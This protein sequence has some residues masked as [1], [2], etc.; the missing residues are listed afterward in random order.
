MWLSVT[1][2]WRGIFKD[3]NNYDKMFELCDSAKKVFQRKGMS[4]HVAECEMDIASWYR[5][6]GYFDK[7]LELLE[8]ARNIFS[9]NNRETSL[10]FC[11][12][13]IGNLFAKMSKCDQAI[14]SFEEAKRIFRKK[15]QKDQ[16]VLCDINMAGEYR[17]KGENERAISLLQRGLK[18]DGLFLEYR[19]RGFIELGRNFKDRG[20]I[21]RSRKYFEKAIYLIEDVCFSFTNEELQRL[22]WDQLARVYHEMAEVCFEEKDFESS[23]KY[24][25]KQ[26]SRYI[27][28]GMLEHDLAADNCNIRRVAYSRAEYSFGAVSG[29]NV[30]SKR[31]NRLH[32]GSIRS[33]KAIRKSGNGIDKN[34]RVRL[35]L[36]GESFSEMD[37]GHAKEVMGNDILI[38]L[39]PMETGTGR[40][41]CEEGSTN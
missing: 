1:N 30:S 31:H 26:K 13:G 34:N 35:V 37:Y 36:A 29:K 16:V 9:E 25:E 2:K 23:F 7:A 19:V 11:N 41:Y 10:A 32:H 22:F 15:R 6:M 8:S 27:S 5:H 12:V 28:Q 17:I 38:E 21:K 20:Q 18:G 40:L 33:V 4:Q 14:K 3:L 24:L 39:F